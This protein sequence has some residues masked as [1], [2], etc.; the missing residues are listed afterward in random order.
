MD[1]V[2]LNIPYDFLKDLIR[3]N[4]HDIR[5]GLDNELIA[6]RFAIEHA[7]QQVTSQDVTSDLVVELAGATSSDPIGDMVEALAALEPTADEANTK[8]KWLVG[9]LAW[10]LENSSTMKDPLRAVEEV[11]ADFDYPPELE[12]FVRYM[13]FVPDADSN[14]PSVQTL[15]ERWQKYVAEASRSLI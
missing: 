12:P 1:V 6:K 8:K 11:Y 14:E 13:P 10:L 3:L 5:F 15:M 7:I 4:W 9:V 2:K